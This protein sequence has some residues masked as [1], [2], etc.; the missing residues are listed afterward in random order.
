[1]SNDATGLVDLPATVGGYAA[2][3]FGPLVRTFARMV[4]GHPGAGGALTVHLRGE[5]LVEIWTG[6]A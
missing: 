5:P 2:A 4:G 1:M 6:E 3:E